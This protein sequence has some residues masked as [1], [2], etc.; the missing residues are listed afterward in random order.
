MVNFLGCLGNGFNVTS[1]IKRGDLLASRDRHSP[2]LQKIGLA[3]RGGRRG[4]GPPRDDRRLHHHHNVTLT[5]ATVGRSATMK[6]VAKNLVGQKTVSTY[7]K[8]IN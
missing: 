5:R 7:S 6:C 3:E 2:G 4:R 8:P 1:R